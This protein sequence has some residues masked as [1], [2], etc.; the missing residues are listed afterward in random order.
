MEKVIL[1]NVL[2]TEAI[3]MRDEIRAAA[4]EIKIDKPDILLRILEGFI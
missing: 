1:K 2:E 3:K 4:N